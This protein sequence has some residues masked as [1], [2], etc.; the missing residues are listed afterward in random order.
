MQKIFKEIGYIKY[1]DIVCSE[2]NYDSINDYL[3]DISSL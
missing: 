1:K 2:N 3:S